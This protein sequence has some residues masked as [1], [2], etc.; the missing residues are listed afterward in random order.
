VFLVREEPVKRWEAGLNSQNVGRGAGKAVRAPPL[1]LVPKGGEFSHHM[2]SRGEHVP[3]VPKNSKEQRGRQTVAQ[4]EGEA[5][6]RRGQTF[7]SHEGCLGFCQTPD[8]V[9]GCGEG[10]RKP[11]SQ[12]PQLDSRSKD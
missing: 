5:H 2:D 1:G 9:R 7:D 12:P 11:V 3:T 8:E 6:P 4:E 10:G